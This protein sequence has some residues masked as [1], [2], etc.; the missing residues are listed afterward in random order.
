MTVSL[1]KDDNKIVLTDSLPKFF[2]QFIVKQHKF[3]C[4]WTKKNGDFRVGNFDLKFRKRYKTAEGVWKKNKGKRRLGE[5]ALDTYCVAFD[6]D[7]QDYRRITY[8]TI[9]YLEVDKIK[10]LVKVKVLD[11]DRRAMELRP[12]NKIKSN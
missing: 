4:A 3:K 8:N 2:K 11:S 9:E 1:V 5:A 12:V 6:L 10:Y 7:K